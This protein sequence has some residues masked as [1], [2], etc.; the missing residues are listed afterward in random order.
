MAGRGFAVNDAAEAFRQFPITFL[1]LSPPM[2]HE[3]SEMIMRNRASFNAASVRTVQIG[4]GAVTKGILI[5]CAAVFP[6][7]RVVV[8]HGMTGGGGYF[9]WPF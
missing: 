6:R 7:A 4:G 2:V 3:F 8:A 1:A 9:R 5:K